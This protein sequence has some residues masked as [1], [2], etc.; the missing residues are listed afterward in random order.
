MKI[1]DNSR[2][3]VWWSGAMAFALFGLI[4]V[5]NRPL[6]TEAAP[7]GILSLQWAWTKEAARTIVASW[8]QSGVLKAAF[9][10]IWLDFPFALAYGTTLSAIF[11]RVCRMLK[12]TSFK[13]SL[14][15]RY[16]P[17]LPLLAAFLDMV[18]NVALLKMMGGS[19]GPSW[20]PIAAICS[21]AKFS[22]L[23][24]SILAVL[25]V[26]VRYRSSS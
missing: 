2:W 3:A 21:T 22:I 9:W 11:S 14:F 19:D 6:E 15:G 17:F 23:A 25:L 16:A 13:S 24:I 10:N 1:F 26:W 12:G 8:A 7:L 4:S 20:P 18:E 5:L